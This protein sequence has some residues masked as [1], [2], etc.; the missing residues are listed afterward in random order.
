MDPKGILA[1]K[2]TEIFF[3]VMLKNRKKLLISAA[4]CEKYSCKLN[5]YLH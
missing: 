4:I 5:P 3:S 1:I 2:D